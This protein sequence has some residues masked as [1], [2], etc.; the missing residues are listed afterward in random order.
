M[1]KAPRFLGREEAT[2]HFARELTVI[3]SQGQ[4]LHLESASRVIEKFLDSC[5]DCTELEFPEF[6]EVNA[7][8]S[9]FK[10]NPEMTQILEVFY[11]P[12]C[13]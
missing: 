3:I 6:S 12:A 8:D 2:E 10:F 13:F 11:S 4:A 1:R 5:T 9:C 7:E